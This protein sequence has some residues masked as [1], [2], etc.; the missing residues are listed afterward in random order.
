[1]KNHER[2]LKYVS[3]DTE[4]DAHSQTVPTTEKQKA[5]GQYLVDE[6]KSMGIADA[7]MDDKGYVYGTVPAAKGCENAPVLGLIAHMDTVSAAPGANIKAR[8]EEK[9]SGGDILLNAEKNIYM[10]TSD[11]PSMKKYIGQD[12]I[13][14]DGTTLLGADD[15]AGVAEIMTVAETLMAHPELPH[16]TIKIGFTPDEEV[17]RGANYFDVEGFGA[18]FAYTV[19]GG[20]LGELAYENFNAA[21]AHLTIH[22]ISSHTGGA[23]NVM[24]NSALLGMEFHSMLPV[25]E[26]PAYTENREGFSH[27]DEIHGSVETT[28]MDYIIRDHDKAKFEEKKARFHKIA[29]YL[30]EKYGQGTF[31]LEVKDSYYNMLEQI[32]PHFQL[33]EKA[34]EAFAACGIETIEI[35]VRGGTDGARLSFKGLPCPNLC[36]GG[37]NFHGRFE[38]VSIQAMEKVV[39]VL[40]KL[41]EL[42]VQ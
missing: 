38:Y 4:S 7:F 19:D 40:L 42:H 32:K 3:F 27:L 28:T 30:N 33:I 9:Y 13:V 18:N 6:M 41:V 36:T 29:D 14:T 20:E 15:K 34:R 8:I 21:S 37:E 10:K 24:V 39:E 2:F 12:L 1:M 31:E 5:L 17:G 22:G 35:P 25:F 23:K 26:N 16:G 11:Y